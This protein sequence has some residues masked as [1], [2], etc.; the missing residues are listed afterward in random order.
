MG[1]SQSEWRGYFL[2]CASEGNDRECLENRSWIMRLRRDKVKESPNLRSGQPRISLLIVIEDS[3]TP[4]PARNGGIGRIAEVDKE[5][6]SRLFQRVAEDCDCERL[7]RDAGGKRQRAGGRGVI[8][9]R[10]GA[11][12]GGGVVDRHGLAAGG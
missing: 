6:L 3:A 10:R 7:A 5:A 8:T 4:S 2:F 12:I 9:I 1:G 11:A